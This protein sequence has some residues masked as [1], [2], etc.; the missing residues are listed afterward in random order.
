MSIFNVIV[1]LEDF[2]KKIIG[3]LFLMI[4]MVILG[5][6]EDFEN[7]EEKNGVMIT[8]ATQQP[9]TGIAVDYYPRSLISNT[10]GIK[11][12]I[13]Y[14]NGIKDGIIREFYENGKPSIETVIKA[15]KKQGMTKEYYSTGKIK[16]KRPYKNDVLDGAVEEYHENGAMSMT[17]EYKSGK[18]TGEFREFRDNKQLKARTT[19]QNGVVVER[20]EF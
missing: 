13:D 9:F 15:G 18:Q 12:K 8:K 6:S 11:I 17:G 16:A 7:L 2:M 5:K 10:R 19:Y 20:K 14:K 1:S 4:T 3:I